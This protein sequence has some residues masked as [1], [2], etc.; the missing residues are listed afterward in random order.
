MELFV[1][2]KYI[3]KYWLWLA[4]GLMAGVAIA[5]G[6]A[7]NTPDAYQATVSIFVQKEAAPPNANYFTY[8]GYYAQ[9]TAASYAETAQQ[10]LKN[11]EIV[12][13]AAQTANLSTD[14]KSISTIK[15]RIITELES[16]QL[17]RVD[18]TMPQR[19]QAFE[20][21][22]GL[23]QALKS[24]TSELNKTGDASLSTEQVNEDPFVVKVRPLA[25]L[26]GVVGGLAG[27]VLST[28]LVAGWIYFQ[29]N[30]KKYS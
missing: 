19:D 6:V 13:R 25:W 7:I 26:Y 11:D 30:R 28:V 3:I 5:V 10:L 8:E 23:S 14:V 15:K 1:Y 17:I 16:P 18:I 20:L 24:R 12:K 4:I 21:A 22:E 27:L 29:H 9:Q 2:V